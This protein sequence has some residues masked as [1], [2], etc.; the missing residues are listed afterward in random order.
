MPKKPIRCKALGVLKMPEYRVYRQMVQRCYLLTAP[1]YPYYGAKGV[2]VCD[3]WRFG[4]DGR[5]GFELFIED[6][7][8]RPD[9][10]TLDRIDPMKPYEPANCRWATWEVQHN[11]LRR[12]HSEEERLAYTK[13]MSLLNRGEASANAILTEAQVAKIKRRALDGDRTSDLAR[14][15]GVAPQTVCNIKHGRKWKHVEPADNDDYEFAVASEA[16]RL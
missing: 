10:L 3:R 13:R 16:L 2:T 8:R 5:A 12:H 9:G 11:N 14:E 7:G 15:F 1:N 6:L 4:E